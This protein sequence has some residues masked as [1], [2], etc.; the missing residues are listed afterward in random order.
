MPD[1]YEGGVDYVA[2][3]R[4]KTWAITEYLLLGYGARLVRSDEGIWRHE[5]FKPEAR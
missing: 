4:G 1:L 2:K 5:Q 3:R